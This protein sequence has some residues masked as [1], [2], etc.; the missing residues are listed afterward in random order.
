MISEIIKKYT[1]ENWTF[2]NIEKDVFKKRYAWV[3]LLPV[4]ENKKYPWAV[5]KD[6]RNLFYLCVSYD[7]LEDF[8][9]EN[10]TWTTTKLLTEIHSRLIHSFCYPNEESN[11]N[12][13]QLINVSDT[14][15]LLNLTFNMLERSLLWC[16]P[17]PSWPKD[18]DYILLKIKPI[19]ERFSEET[20]FI[21]TN[22][23]KLKGV[24]QVSIEEYTHVFYKF[25]VACEQIQNGY[26]YSE[27]KTIAK[28]AYGALVQSIQLC[29]EYLISYVDEQTYQRKIDEIIAKET[30]WAST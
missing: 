8:N 19:I 22:E 7:S 13:D 12:L 21:Q 16:N 26:L 4:A 23:L 24:Y 29:F 18:F 2:L 27:L 30:V 5:S 10:Q 20:N 3:R 15:A 6:I 14:S 17:E 11:Q 9:K 25:Q 28:Q 1:A